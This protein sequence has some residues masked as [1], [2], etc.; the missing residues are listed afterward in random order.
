MA[1]GITTKSISKSDIFNYIS[2]VDVLISIFPQITSIPCLIPSPLR[3]DIHPSFSIY[4]SNTNHIYYKDFAVR[5]ER[6]SLMDLLCKYWNCSFKTALTKI[7][8][9]PKVKSKTSNIKK[10]SDIKV[11]TRKKSNTESKIQVVVRSW[12]DYDYQYWREYGIEMPWLKY[13]EIYPI[14]HKIVIK[15]NKNGKWNKHV[16]PTEKYSYCFIERKEGV[17]SLKI[18]QPFSKQC[19]W[20]SKMDKSII[21][22]WTKIPEKG[23][24]VIICSSL[25]DALCI[26]C[27]LHIPTLCLQGEGYNISET[28]KKELLKRY[29]KVYISFDVDKTGIED[30]IKLAESTGFTNIIPDLGNCK[31]YSDYYKSLKNKEQFKQ[32]S[33]LFN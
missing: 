4:L 12:K 11:F 2:E 5:G 24:R 28:A 6:G 10:R 23:D 9:L 18:Y 30:G 21:G 32:L 14:S 19:K 13:A 29:K 31:D 17:V 3:E 25:K 15:K 22:L 8:D 16:F 26:S 27:Q 33:V 7:A 1:I 20:C